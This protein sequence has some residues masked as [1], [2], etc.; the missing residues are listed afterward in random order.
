MGPILDGL[1]GWTLFAGIVA[2]L[3]GCVARFM[4][5]PSATA[6]LG[7]SRET[8]NRAAARLALAGA[9]LLVPAM[10][11]YFLRQLLEFRDP[12][13]PWTEDAELLLTGTAWGTT[14]TRGAMAA[15]VALLVS[16]VVVRGVRAAWWIAL[17]VTLALGAFPALTGHASGADGPRTLLLGADVLH[18]WAASGW[19]GGLAFVL[20]AE[21]MWRRAERGPDAPPSL[22]PTLVPIFSPLAVGCVGLLVLSGLVGAWVHL[23]GPAAL[24]TSRYGLILS[25]KLGVVAI[26]L[27]LGFLNWRRLTPRLGH[28]AGPTALRRAATTELLVVQAVLIVTALLVRTAPPMG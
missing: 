3:G 24:I 15:V 21:W 7:E 20:S 26:A 1:T 18:V 4:L 14:W 27:G 25:A 5:V 2:A 9:F 17:P 11:L 19:I 23:P 10:A 12:Y 6:E 8:L 22:L 13:V 28:E 16:T